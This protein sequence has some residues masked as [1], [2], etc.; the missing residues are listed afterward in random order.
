M[1]EPASASVMIAQVSAAM[2]LATA[3][4][5][6]SPTA[7]VTPPSSAATLASNTPCVGFMMRV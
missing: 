2:P 7:V 6:G 3:R 5:P 1:C 4:A